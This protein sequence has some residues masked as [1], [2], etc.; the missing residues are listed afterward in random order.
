MNSK[1]STLPNFLVVGA[2]KSGT[3][4]LFHYLNQHQEIFIPKK[5]ECRFFSNMPKGSQGPGDKRLDPTI[6]TDLDEYCALFE[7]A[8]N[9]RAIGDVSPDYLYYCRKSIP[10]VKRTLSDPKI[11]ILLRNPVERAYSQY[12][13]FVRD[14]RE[15]LSF[16]EALEQEKKRKQNNWEWAWRY[17]EVGMYYEQVKAFMDNFKNVRIYLFDDLKND[18]L[19]LVQD[20]YR[21]LEID[22]TFIPTVKTKHNISGVPKNELWHEFLTSPPRSISRLVNVLLPQKFIKKVEQNLKNRN[23]KNPV[24]EPEIRKRL[25]KLYHD[26]IILLQKLLQIDLSHWL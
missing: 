12:L 4:S 23:L 7:S 21:Y 13:H 17:S 1:S 11:I 14:G 2:A 10:N 24:M 8:G 3:T 16:A 6:V 9:K 25:Q 15:K 18:T 22:A 5:K 20:V 19:T 26:D